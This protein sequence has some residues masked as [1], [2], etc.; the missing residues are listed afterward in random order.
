M[1]RPFNL[2]LAASCCLAAALCAA[3]CQN[4]LFRAAETPY[5]AAPERLKAIEPVDLSKVQYGPPVPAE[6]AMQRAT[7]GGFQPTKYDGTR[8]MTLAEVRA[9]SLA[10]NLDLRVQLIAPDIAR[11][12]I[13]EEE[14]KFEGLFFADY[15]RNGNN[16]VTQLQ[17]GEGILN[18]QIDM[19]VAV[20][21]ATGGR[22]S[23]SP[24]YTQSTNQAAAALGS[25][26]PD[27]GGIIMSISQPLL[28]DAGIQRNTA[29]IRVAKL[30]GQITDS[31]TKLEAIRILANAD[32]AYWN[33]YRTYRELEVRK[34]QYELAMLQLDR[35]RRRVDA[36]DAPQVEVL[37]AESGVGSTLENVILADAALRNRQRD[38]KRIVNDPNMP[39]SDGTALIPA[40]QPNPLGLQLDAFTLADSAVRNRM[41]ML[42]LE[43]QLAVDASNVE[44]ARNASLP[45][46]TVDYTYQLLGQ[47]SGPASAFGNIGDAD[48]YT[49]SA[50]AEIP[51]GNEV[52]LSQLRR[53]VLQRVQRLA[54]KDARAQAIRQEVL[55]AVDNLDTSWQRILA[56]RLEAVLAARTYEAE[57]RQF[58]VGLRTS[59]DVL[60]AS[61]RL[62]D[63]QS[64][65]VNALTGYE[66]SLIDAAFATGTLVGGSKIRWDEL[67]MR[68]PAK[69]PQPGGEGV[70]GAAA[71]VGSAAGAA[72]EPAGTVPDPAA[73]AAKP[74]S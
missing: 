1:R 64:R 13:S 8:T 42:E 27:Q 28:R 61:A 11:T 50:R 14:A 55:N 37:R 5:T 74:A 7:A 62:G 56:A 29:S 10:N 33:L 45:L 53:T 67:E 59:T 41:E 26:A 66:I 24:Q 58:E 68:D 38:L 15:Q 63:A 31:R 20:P 52:R 48:Q 22:L 71:T 73:P 19:G 21:L 35:A 70:V 65:E 43:L 30:E 2:R 39:M 69:P 32:K 46:F 23:F 9:L 72:A 51:I 16:L 54:T 36:G 18:E 6:E 47:G 60:D 3:G 4:D 25:G 12:R 49:I 17:N 44:V 57:K 34:Q 40:S